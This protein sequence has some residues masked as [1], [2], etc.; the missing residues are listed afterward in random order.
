MVANYLAGDS[1]EEAAKKQGFTHHTCGAALT[2]AGIKRRTQSESVRQRAVDE[3][4]FANIDTEEKAYWLGFL[5]ADGNVYARTV[6]L[7]LKSSDRYHVVAF[8]KA[9]KS[10][11]KVVDK[12]NDGGYG[13]Q[14]SMLSYIR[15]NSV[16]LVADL[17]KLG[18]V[19]RKSLI[20]R[21]WEGPEHLMRH[22]WRGVIDGDG[23]FFWDERT[24]SPYL[25]LVGS[26]W[27]VEAFAEFITE[28]V[29]HQGSLGQVGKS[30]T[31]SFGGVRGPQVIARLL[32]DDATVFLERKKLLA[33]EFQ[34]RELRQDPFRWKHLTKESLEALL[35]KH[36][37]WVGVAKELGGSAKVLQGIG[38]RLGVARVTRDWSKYTPERLN[39]MHKRLGSWNA[40]AAELGCPVSDVYLACKRKG[41]NRRSTN[42]AKHMGRE[43]LE[44]LYSHHGSWEEVAATLKISSAVLKYRRKQLGM[45]ISEKYSKYA[46]GR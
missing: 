22:Y 7:G 40:V 13:N 37:S 10:D 25:S 2:E 20:V 19:P 17:A 16:K 46:S 30:F 32:Y 18:I 8:G 33:D 12:Q 34:T 41:M 11:A 21:P 27:V 9:L 4:F 35:L 1:M 28:T 24:H 45:P 36:D 43:E 6:F 14:T 44:N 39:E 29:G 26:K 3:D 42:Q 5:L 23:S 15:I 31:V 38:A